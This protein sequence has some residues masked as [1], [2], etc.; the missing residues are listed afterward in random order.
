MN[1]VN[2]TLYKKTKTRLIIYAIFV[3]IIGIICCAGIF[4]AT[5]VLPMIDVSIGILLIFL[6]VEVIL[7]KKFYNLF[8]ALKTKSYVDAIVSEI[9]VEKCDGDEC[10]SY[11]NAYRVF[12]NYTY[13]EERYKNVFWYALNDERTTMKNLWNYLPPKGQ[14]IELLINPKKPTKILTAGTVLW[15]AVGGQK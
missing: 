5:S 12:V 10:G 6:P 15:R 4:K 7:F 3:F 9:K 8:Y 2:N 14:Q 13:K 11:Y 1:E